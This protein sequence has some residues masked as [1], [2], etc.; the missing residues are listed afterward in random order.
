MNQYN[1]KR[2]IQKKINYQPVTITLHD[3]GSDAVRSMWVNY[4]R[5]YY[6]DPS[7]NY[8]GQGT[9]TPGYNNR[10][11][12]DNL[13]S[14]SDWGYNGQGPTGDTKPAFF[15]DIKIYTLNRG[16]FKS[17]TLINPII[18]DFQ[19]DTHDV[20]A[21]GD[22]MQHS[23][24][25]NYETVKYGR[26]R[27]GNQVKGF[28]DPSVY[29]TT[30]SPLRPGGTASTFGVGGIFDAGESIIEDLASGNILGAIRTGGTLKNTLKNVDVSQLLSSDIASEAISQGV[31]FISGLGSNNSNASGFNIPSFGASEGLDTL[32][33]NFSGTAGDVGTSLATTNT[34]STL[35][36]SL[37]SLRRQFAPNFNTFGSGLTTELVD[38]QKATQQ[39]I[40]VLESNASTFQTTAQTATQNLQPALDNLVQGLQPT[41]NS[42]KKNIV[43]DPKAGVAGDVT[44]NGRQVGG[45]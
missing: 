45:Q 36:D 9:N 32:S 42:L 21:S 35:S 30:P 34:F 40:A 2:Y 5:Y 37:G 31:N 15:K 14:V 16:N 4:Y 33:Q 27:I 28:A 17:Y 29:D 44:S 20:S 1:R 12:Y 38:I 43:F 26:G 25:V 8:D 23:M 11:I 18:S 24:T 10:D 41:I 3:D 7:Y 13:R 39:G 6:N 22:F 19:H